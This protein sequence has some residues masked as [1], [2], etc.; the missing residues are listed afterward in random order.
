MTFV[1]PVETSVLTGP[2]LVQFNI[3]H[4]SWKGDARGARRGLECDREAARVRVRLR[5]PEGQVPDPTGPQGAP[6]GPP[7]PVPLTH[8]PAGDGAGHPQVPGHPQGDH[9]EAAAP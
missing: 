9:A 5:S 2:T 8:D 1:G 7:P 3:N 6:Q 4:C